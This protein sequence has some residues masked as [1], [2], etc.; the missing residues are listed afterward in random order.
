MDSS[1]SSDLQEPVLFSGT[2]R[3]NLDPFSSYK[4]HRL[5]EVLGKVR[6]TY[7]KYPDDVEASLVGNSTYI[8]IP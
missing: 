7:K 6:K 1:I 5:W 8:S 4:D 2:M 3:R